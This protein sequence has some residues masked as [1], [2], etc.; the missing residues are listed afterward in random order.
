MS[1]YLRFPTIVLQ[2]I[3]TEYSAYRMW[4]VAAPIYNPAIPEGPKRASGSGSG[5]LKKCGFGSFVS[6]GELSMGSCVAVVGKAD[7]S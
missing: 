4:N 5:H 7:S 3:K 1:I 6:S 2:S